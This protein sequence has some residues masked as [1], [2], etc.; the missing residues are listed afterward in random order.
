MTDFSLNLRGVNEMAVEKMQTAINELAKY[1]KPNLVIYTNDKSYQDILTVRFPN[2]QVKLVNPFD[3]AKTGKPDNI[4]WIDG[5][6]LKG[7]N[8]KP[9]YFGFYDSA[10]M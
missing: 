9:T 4:M 3:V 6:K 5:K 1:L 7:K 8:L 2:N 10:R